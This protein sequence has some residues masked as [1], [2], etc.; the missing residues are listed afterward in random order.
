MGQEEDKAQSEIWAVSLC[1]IGLRDRLVI[2]STS[3]YRFFKYIENREVAKLVLKDRGLKKIRMGIEGYPTHKE[4]VRCRPRARPEGKTSLGFHFE[5]TNTAVL[6]LPS[7]LQLH[8]TAVSSHVLGERRSTVAPCRLPVC[9]K[10]I[11]EQS[12]RCEWW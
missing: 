8:S 10:S 12:F 2:R 5:R 7:H 1:L 3:M 9:A 6:V 11:R 4:K